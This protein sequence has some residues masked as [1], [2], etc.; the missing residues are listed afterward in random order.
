MMGDFQLSAAHSREA[1]RHAE[2][3]GDPERL[4]VAI[5]ELCHI[6]VVL[7]EAI[8]EAAMARALELEQRIPTFPP[9]QRPSFQLGILRM[10]RDE[11]D[12]ARP[13]LEAELD[14]IRAQGD[15]AARCGVYF[16]LAELE[17][18]AGDWA[19]AARHSR[20][21]MALATQAGIE[22]E[23]ATCIM[24]HGTLQAHL[25]NLDEAERAA[26]EA[27]QLARATGDLMVEVRSMG[28]LGFV[29]LSRDRPE[30]ALEWLGPARRTMFRVGAGEL[31]ISQVA[32]HELDAL[33]ALQQLD[34]AEQVLGY[35]EAKGAISDR[36]W[37]AAVAGRGRGLVASAR[38]DAVAAREHLAAALAAHERLPQPFELARTLLALGQIERRAKRRA[39]ARQALTRALDLFDVLGAP[40]WSEKAAAELARIPGRGP[41]P[42]TLTETERRIA[43][44]VAGGLSNKEVA[45]RLFITVRTVES[46]LSRVYEKLGVRSR[47]ELASRSDLRA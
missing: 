18:R 4:A 29:E 35:I 22:Q 10:Y 8:D 40:R 41:G 24:M 28:V 47:T 39:E 37:H 31:S 3:A 21:A 13:L 44:L 27:L 26:S 12:A 38:G 42:T 46:T 15:E 25:G 6:R 30:A 23:Q 34:E 9:Y 2:R 45:A 16:R 32:N 5:A 20:D 17:L 19:R 7:G 36:A 33:I 1:V 14:R 43:E 11:P